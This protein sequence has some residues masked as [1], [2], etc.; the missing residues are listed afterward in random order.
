MTEALPTKITPCPIIESV[1]EIIF[2]RNLEI[3]PSAVYGKVYDALKQRYP[4]AHNLPLFQLPEEIRLKDDNLKHK[5][6]HKFFNEEFEVLVG[7][8]IV[9][10]VA[11]K[12][13][14]GWTK[15]SQE[16]N[17]VFDVFQKANITSSITRISLKYVDMFE[18]PIVNQIDISLT[19]SLGINE[20]L[21]IQLRTLL[22]EK[23]SLKA[24]LGIMN[25]VTIE[26]L[27][28]A[29]E[30]VSMLDIDV[31]KTYESKDSCTYEDALKV[32]E[33]SHQYQKELFFQLVSEEFLKAHSYT[34]E[35]D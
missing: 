22:P 28:E 33:D 29:K 20:S 27:G 13:Y 21:E 32:L 5:P 12:E 26:Y 31:F 25:N 35:R 6:W 8:N 1:A 34:V 14:Q 30:N 15:Y 10:V 4:D 2:D 7:G 16:I 3:E 17:Y 9:A 24:I 11:K 18:C 19:S 23:N